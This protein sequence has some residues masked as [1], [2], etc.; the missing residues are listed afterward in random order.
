MKI[1]MNYSTEVT[2]SLTDHYRYTL[3]VQHW[4][5]VRFHLHYGD[6]MDCTVYDS[7]EDAKAAIHQTAALWGW[8]ERKVFLKK[9]EG[10]ETVVLHH[11]YRVKA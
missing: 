7:V 3:E 8:D 9:W 4:D 2:K 1:K 5:T 6:Q 10:T 11:R